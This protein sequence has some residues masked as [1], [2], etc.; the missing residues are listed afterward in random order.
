MKTPL[1]QNRDF[2]AG[3]LFLLIGGIGF[4][5]ALSYP[6]GT[7]EKMGPGYFPRVLSGVLIAFGIVTLV[8]GLKSGEKVQGS[9]GWLPLAMLTA[10]LLAF[11]FLMEHVG[12]IPALVVMLFTSAYAGKEAKFLEILALTVIMCIAATAIFIW[13]LKLPYPLFVFP[14]M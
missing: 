3:M 9:W 12:L 13:G 8:R 1:Q 11:G 10:S 14:G 6:F 4:Y 7:L 2:L 5:M